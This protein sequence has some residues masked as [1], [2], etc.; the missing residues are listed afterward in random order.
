MVNG[1]IGTTMVS[2]F[3]FYLSSW[4]FY[5]N[6]RVSIIAWDVAFFARQQTAA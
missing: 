6:R 5:G 2:V 1:R 3:I 4:G